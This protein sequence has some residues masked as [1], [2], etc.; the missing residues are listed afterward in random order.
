MMEPTTID[1]MNGMP[2]C[3]QMRG[4]TY[5]GGPPGTLAMQVHLMKDLDTRLE[6][7][8]YF[9]KRECIGREEGHLCACSGWRGHSGPASRPCPG[10]PRCQRPRN[11]ERDKQGD[12]RLQGDESPRQGRGRPGDQ[13]VHRERRDPHNLRPDSKGGGNPQGVRKA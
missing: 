1:G 7:D 2:Q 4:L 9:W 8:A 6:S 5:D 13:A 10:P 3:L 11:R 12:R